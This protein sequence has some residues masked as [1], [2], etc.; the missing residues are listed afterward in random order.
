MK[1][2]YA[3]SGTGSFNSD[4]WDVR[5][6]YTVNDKTHLFGRFSRFTDTLTGTTLFGPAGG[7]GFGLGGYGGTSVGANDS[8]AA[9][10]DIVVNTKLVTDIRLGYFRYNI[11]TS[12]YDQGTAFATNLGI[13]DLNTG[14]VHHLGCP[15][16]PDP[17]GRR[18][19][20][21]TSR[22]RLQARSTAPA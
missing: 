20:R 9:G 4:Q 16:L 6:D 2:N 22:L 19:L 21:R 15:G 14:A 7:A 10:V 12:K 13:P 5:G 8:A 11:D 3:A 1:N 17:G 18:C